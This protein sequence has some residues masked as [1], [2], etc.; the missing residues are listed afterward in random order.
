MRFWRDRTGLRM[1]TCLRCG[2]SSAA[3]DALMH[4]RCPSCG[5]PHIK[6]IK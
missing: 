4:D 5:A 1:A 2:R 3:E 6:V